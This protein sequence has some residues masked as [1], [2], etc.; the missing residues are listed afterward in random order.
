MPAI[1]AIGFAAGGFCGQLSFS[2]HPTATQTAQVTIWPT[3]APITLAA[4]FVSSFFSSIFKSFLWLV[5][6]FTHGQCV[7]KYIKNRPRL[8]GRRPLAEARG[9]SIYPAICRLRRA[10]AAAAR[11]AVNGAT[12]TTAK[13]PTRVFATSAATIG[14]L[15]KTC[16]G[17][18]SAAK[19]MRSER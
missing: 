2:I 1:A 13:E 7:F 15:R 4:L 5:D 10:K 12:R 9:N 3:R 17:T 16:G 14:E 8:L 11:N 19:T 18:P 6:P